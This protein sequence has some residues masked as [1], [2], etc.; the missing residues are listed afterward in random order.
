[1]HNNWLAELTNWLVNIDL[2]HHTYAHTS[3]LWLEQFQCQNT[4]HIVPKNK[5]MQSIFSSDMYVT[6]YVEL[7]CNRVEILWLI[8]T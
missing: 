1:M 8:L 5:E 7:G 4:D 3:G 2:T 6:L